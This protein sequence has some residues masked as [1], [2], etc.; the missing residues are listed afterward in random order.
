VHKEGQLDGGIEH[1]CKTRRIRREQWKDKQCLNAWR[2]TIC[3]SCSR[4]R[5]QAKN[6]FRFRRI[7][8]PVFLGSVRI[9]LIQSRQLIVGADLCAPTGRAITW[10][11]NERAHV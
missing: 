4:E 1:E 7:I 11:L 3:H 8:S 10:D 9:Y 5:Y 6:G 2:H